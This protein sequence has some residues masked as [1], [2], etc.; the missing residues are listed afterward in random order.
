MVLEVWSLKTGGPVGLSPGDFTSWRKQ[1]VTSESAC[2]RASQGMGEAF[3]TSFSGELPLGLYKRF[4]ISQWPKDLPCSRTFP[5]NHGQEQA[6][7]HSRPWRVYAIS[8]HSR[9]VVKIN[10]KQPAW[11]IYYLVSCQFV[12][13]FPPNYNINLVW[14]I[15]HSWE[16]TLFAGWHSLIGRLVG[17]WFL[18]PC[19][20]RGFSI[21][22]IIPGDSSVIQFPSLRG[23]FIASWSLV[24]S[25][26]SFPII[27]LGCSMQKWFHA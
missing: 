11:S 18:V 27:P 9:D 24:C 3:M 15:L 8:K 23:L 13:K 5:Q 20:P 26:V 2:R 1:V 21:Y 16:I 10:K 22:V 12:T 19:H 7:D 6:F 17:W 25:L 4:L 14:L